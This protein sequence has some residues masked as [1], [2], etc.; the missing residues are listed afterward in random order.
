[1]TPI[2]HMYAVSRKSPVLLC[3]GKVRWPQS[4]DLS[5]LT[6]LGLLLSL[7]ASLNLC[8]DIRKSLVLVVSIHLSRYSFSSSHDLILT[9]RATLTYSLFALVEIGTLVYKRAFISFRFPSAVYR[10]R[11]LTLRYDSSFLTFV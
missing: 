3:H 7:L 6:P 10:L 5:H 2:L 11:D 9:R 8:V 4:V 1:M